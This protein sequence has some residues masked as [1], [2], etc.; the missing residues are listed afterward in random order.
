MSSFSLWL[1]IKDSKPRLVVFG[2]FLSYFNRSKIL[3]LTSHSSSFG[4]GPVLHIGAFSLAQDHISLLVA[5]GEGANGWVMAFDRDSMAEVIVSFSV[6]FFVTDGFFMGV[7]RVR[8]DG[9]CWRHLDASM[10]VKR[11]S[12]LVLAIENLHKSG[13]FERRSWCREMEREKNE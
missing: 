11:D 13:G 1:A 2:F 7:S 4:I 10:V 6:F 3:G 5:T 9:S 12:D 8:F